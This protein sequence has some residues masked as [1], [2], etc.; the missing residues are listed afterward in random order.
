MSSFKRRINPSSGSSASLPLPAGVKPSS[1]SSPVPLISTGVPAL[2]DLLSGGGLS[3][4]SSLL[5]F[6]STGTAAQSAAQIGSSSSTPAASAETDHAA[7]AAA[8]PYAELLLSYSIA[9]GIASDH[10]NIVIGEDVWGLV[11]GLMA[12]AGDLD[13]QL[14]ARLGSKATANEEADAGPSDHLNAVADEDDV[15]PHASTSALEAG[16]EGGRGSEQRE[17]EMKIAWRYHSMKQF[18]TTVNEPSTEAIPF[19][20]TFDLSKRIDSRIIQHAMDTGKLELVDTSASSSGSSGI[21]S[22]ELA[23]TAI[24]AAASRCRQL[25][26]ASPTS[27]PPVLRIAIRSLGSPSWVVPRGRSRAV[28]SVRFLSRLR[29]L[30]RTHSLS[31]TAPLPSMSI[32][33]LSPHLLR[34]TTPPTNLAHRLVHSVDAAIS[35]SAF[36]PSPALRSAF[37]A[38]TGAVKILNTPSVGTLTNPS[39]RSSVLRGMGGAPA[40]GREGGAGGGENNLAF[41][42]RRKRVVIE[43]LHLDVE[44]GVSERR[45]K[46]AKG[47]EVETANKTAA[48][49]STGGVGGTSAR[50][51]TEAPTAGQVEKGPKK[52]GGLSSLRQRGLAVAATAGGQKEYAV[53]MDTATQRSHSH[54]AKPPNRVANSRAEDLEF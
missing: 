35:L 21:N 23:Y 22:Y 50:R 1:F 26:S 3:S 45:T 24:E 7:R 40:G 36:S 15:E 49:P 42:V 37:P 6:P 33:T 12:R 52:F 18:N 14:V 20:Q 29:R 51:P 43:T 41:K 25:A 48:A 2:D 53:E 11:N 17:R 31:P 39:I 4:S 27:A 8:E 44:G 47:V 9:Q 28:E 5:V 10:I 19:C 38:Y 54:T 30:L 13:D 46:P 34:P 16:A 32:L